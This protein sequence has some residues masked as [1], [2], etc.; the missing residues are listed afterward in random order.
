MDVGG[1]LR[2]PLGSLATQPAHCFMQ[3]DGDAVAVADGRVDI[4]RDFRGAV[5]TYRP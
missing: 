5:I 3:G 4:R 1:P 2:W